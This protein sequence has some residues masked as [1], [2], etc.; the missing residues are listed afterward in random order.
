[1]AQWEA[2]ASTTHYHNDGGAA[3]LGYSEVILIG[4]QDSAEAEVEILGKDGA[5][6]VVTEYPTN[7]RFDLHKRNYLL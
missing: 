2:I 5:W 6:S 7:T 1:M 3:A 4:N